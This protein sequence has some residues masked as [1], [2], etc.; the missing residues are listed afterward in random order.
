VKVQK[1]IGLH[2]SNSS[3]AH[4][5]GLTHYCMDAGTDCTKCGKNLNQPHNEDNVLQP[6]SWTAKQ[7][8]DYA[9]ID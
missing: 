1:F 3:R 5:Q 9:I 4:T 7:N 6:M 8:Y 2:I